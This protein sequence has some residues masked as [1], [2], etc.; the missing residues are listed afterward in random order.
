MPDDKSKLAIWIP[1]VI[2]A[3]TLV[4]GSGW[5][6]NYI[7]MRESRKKENERL[8]VQYLAPIQTR[9]DLNS[10][11]KKR[12]YEQYREEGWGIL[13][14]YVIKGRGRGRCHFVESS[15]VNI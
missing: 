13:E 14:S 1:I 5:V 7:D 12:I 3:L 8:A 6:K 2:S 9:L 4:A 11:I 15:V 10:S